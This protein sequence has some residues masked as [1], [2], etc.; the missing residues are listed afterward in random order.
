M[1]D[2][3]RSDLQKLTAYAPH[4]SGKTTIA[5]DRLDTNESPLDL[6]HEL[7]EKL[8]W[9][10]QHQI[11]TNRYPDGAQTE[12]KAEIARY[13]NESAAAE[14][15]FSVDNISIGNGSDELI[16][17][18]LIATCL[19]GEGAIFVANPTFSMYEI[20]AQTMGIPVVSGGRSSVDFSIDLQEANSLINS[21]INPPIKVVFV[22]H[23]NSPTANALTPAEI[24][25]L[26][27]LDENILVVIDEAYFE[28]NRTSLVGEIN[29]HPNWI[30]LR[31]FS[32]AFRLANLRV[33]YAIAHPELIN[34]LEK[35]RLPYNLPGFSQTAA[36][37]ALDYRQEILSYIDNTLAERE[38][39]YPELLN[40]SG[41]RVW[42]SDANLFYLRLVERTLA[43]TEAKIVQLMREKGTSIR[44]T[45]E[46]LRITIGTPEENQRMLVRLR[47]VVCSYLNV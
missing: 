23:P 6:P 40:I 33:G 25:W 17:S 20:T 12:L 10:Y 5:I 11:E 31:T 44:H 29:K 2:F 24:D 41:L 39:I 15:R 42:R 16:R 7:K 30:I 43:N 34:V 1:L 3:L 18:L 13:V 8:A 26:H 38:K 19:N 21:Q 32:K 35:I 46:G 14:I 36:L 45:G 9:T 27:G 37:F 28:F 22:V 47:E 4:P